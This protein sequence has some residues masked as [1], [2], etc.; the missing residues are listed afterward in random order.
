MELYTDI[1]KLKSDFYNTK[2]SV[3]ASSDQLPDDI[4]EYDQTITGGYL[5]LFDTCWI[6]KTDYENEYFLIIE[7][8]HWVTSD[9]EELENLLFTKWVIPN[10]LKEGV[11]NE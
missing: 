4:F 7:N 11:S 1:N 9:L 2:R 3:S 5:Y 8:N 10:F 6:A